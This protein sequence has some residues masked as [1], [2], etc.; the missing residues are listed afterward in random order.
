MQ[1]GI[2]GEGEETIAIHLLN[3]KRVKLCERGFG[4]IPVRLFE[5][6]A[7]QHLVL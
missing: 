3:R 2:L 4:I 6:E 5:I 7:E 1:V